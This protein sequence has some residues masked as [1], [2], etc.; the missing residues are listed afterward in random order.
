MGKLAVAPVPVSYSGCAPYLICATD[1]NGSSNQP[2]SIARACSAAAMSGNGTGT[3]FTEDGCMSLRWSIESISSS[4]TFFVMF[5]ATFLPLRSVTAWMGEPAR[6]RTSWE[7]RWDT[8]P[9]ARIRQ[10]TAPEELA[11]ARM[12]DT[13]APAVTSVLPCSCELIAVVLDVTWLMVMC[14]PSAAKKPCCCARNRPMLVTAGTTAT[15]RCGLSTFCWAAV[16]VVVLDDP[17]PAAP[18]AA[19]TNPAVSAVRRETSGNCRGTSGDCREM[20]GN[21]CS[22]MSGIPET[23]PA[24]TWAR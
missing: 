18:A 5:A 12:Y 2:A 20:S 10:V 6:T 4:P 7:C 17:H 15:L 22:D 19:S 13:Y 23:I 24:C 1:R 3:T 9:S 21:F 14:S 11:C 16:R 8:E